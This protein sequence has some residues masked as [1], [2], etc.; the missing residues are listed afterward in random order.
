MI[1]PG[2]NNYRRELTQNDLDGGNHISIFSSNIIDNECPAEGMDLIDLEECNLTPTVEINNEN[3]FVQVF[4]NPSSGI[5]NIQFDTNKGID[6]FIELIDISG[7]NVLSKTASV[8]T[9]LLV[10]PS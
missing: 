3:T 10:L 8:L 1:T 2:P 9:L 5:I 7:K 4:P 6:G